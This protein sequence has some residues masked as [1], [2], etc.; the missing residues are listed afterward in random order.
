MRVS[1]RRRLLGL[2]TLALAAGAAPAALA[3]PKPA[4]TA[5]IHLP[6]GPLDAALLTLAKQTGVSIVFT[7]QMVDGRQARAVDGRMT[8]QQAVTQLIAGTDLEMRLAGE[9]V[10]VLRPRDAVFRT[11]TSPDAAGSA[12]ADPGEV[13][14][15]DAIPTAQEPTVVAEIV[16]GSHIRGVKDT[17]SPVVELS[18][19][20]IDRGGY[21]SVAEA[22]TALPQAFGG[23]VS[24]DSVSTGADP[25]GTNITRGTGVD[26]RGLGADA[27]LVLVNG[28][29]M[30]GAGVYG[31]FSDISSI[32]FV[33][34]GKVNVLLDGAS[35]L[36]GADAVGG[37]VDIR[38]RNNLDGG[39]TRVS[40]GTATQGGYSRYLASQALGRAWP[41]G[42]LLAAYEYTRNDALRG[43]DRPYTGDADLRP[44]GG[45]DRRSA[46]A[47]APGNILRLNAAGA[48]VATYAIPAGQDGTSLK[49]GDF[50]AGTVNRTNQKAAY[51]VIPRSTRHSAVIAA[52]Q[53]LGAV[54][55]SGDLRFAHREIDARNAA[56]TTTLVLTAANPYFVSP[57][58]QS[59]ERIAYA[60]QNEAP[61][62]RNW[63]EAESLGL[64]LG[65]KARL[66][67]GWN[68]DLHGAYA[69]ELGISRSAG[70]INSTN[71][72]EAAGL[73]ADSPLTGFS[74]ARDGYFNPYIGQGSNKA[75][76]LGFIL[77]GWDLSKV[78]GQSKAVDLGFDG[79]LL[80]LP[81]GL[82][83]LAIGGQLRREEL[84]T[85]GARFLSGYAPTAKAPARYSRD[86][87]SA[88]AELN[89]PLVGPGNALPAIERLELSLAGRIEDYDDV[90]ATT[91]P[92][93]GLIWVPRQGLTVKASYGTS[94]RAPA[95]SELNIPYTITPIAVSAQG[96]Q[97]P[98]L[99]YQG[100]NPSLRPETARSW[101]AGVT[102]SPDSVPDLTLSLFVY[103]TRFK[104]R[105]GSP[106]VLSQ[107][108]T[109]TEFAPF[110]TLLSPATNPSDRAKVLAAMADPHAVGLT[111]YA[112]DTYG[113]II[114]LRYVNTGSL[115]VA[116]LDASAA[117]K[118]TVK[119]DP[120]ALN[121]SLS[122]LTRYARKLT[123]ASAKTQLA[124]QAGYP[125]DLRARVSATWTHGPASL[126]TSLI[127]V[128]DLSAETGA[129]IAPWTT[130][131]LQGRWQ[132]KV[133]GAQGLTL[134][135]NVQNLF[136]K[137][138]P[139]YDNPLA[140]GYDP[141]NADPLG[142]LVSLQLTKTW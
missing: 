76:V 15:Q 9:R 124:G 137:A 54:T 59:A 19:E 107:A 101:T 109:S 119:G 57:T 7:S 112:V 25:N 56:P 113:A 139:F 125:A 27:T 140:I 85:G 128:G 69:Q 97:V 32:P 87:R 75:A 66:G 50:T 98:S 28:R 122:W 34:V 102:V 36:Y 10:L 138:P 142:R 141:A 52:E 81:G 62:V 108:L 70:Q 2:S 93:V 24:E 4:T 120:L 14:A 17:A 133:L 40:A 72:S 35:A 55:L 95:L 1:P 123:P 58:G 67:A 12:A 78:R 80:R 127:H 6:P 20:D 64:S 3:A 65:A 53:A 37:V 96:G 103:R 38:L 30:A 116:G 91:N 73:A 82:A 41:G 42:H 129:R 114:D 11:A 84:R 22:L 118:T 92:K 134:T 68:A 105:V 104:D 60:F 111:A 106:V 33:A 131:D 45:S 126:T 100:G 31:D 136:D 44:W 90:G 94:F 117:W 115:D 61:G 83:R 130:F 23:T 5:E 74:A 86:V 21:A 135:L 48:Y 89:A 49:A 18:R 43:A 16:V 13:K 121:A 39:E 99:V 46:V 8:P 26:L 77:S 132:G 51:D 110:R 79:P 63:G 71:L 29:R 47:G 88:Y